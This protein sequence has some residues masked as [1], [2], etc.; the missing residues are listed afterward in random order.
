MNSLFIKKSGGNS[1]TKKKTKSKQPARKRIGSFFG[2]TENKASEITIDDITNVRADENTI[3]VPIE[4][5]KQKPDLTESDIS[6]EEES[7]VQTIPKYKNVFDSNRKYD[8]DQ[9][10][11][12]KLKRF[13]LAQ[14][15]YL[16]EEV[17]ELD[18]NKKGLTLLVPKA[19][20]GERQIPLSNTE[21]IDNKSRRAGS[22]KPLKEI[23]SPTNHFLLIPNTM[24]TT[25]TLNDN[26]SRRVKEYSSPSTTHVKKSV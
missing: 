7:I 21:L 2:K 6:D 13:S 14:D 26:T 8:D 9:P 11:S 16:E 19:K 5:I 10:K 18:Y 15:I 1:K 20:D 24:N 22:S 17:V 12:E 23:E 25:Q 4:L 3:L